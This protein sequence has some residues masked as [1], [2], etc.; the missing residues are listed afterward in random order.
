VQAVTQDKQVALVVQT[1]FA[2]VLQLLTVLV[3]M[4]STITTMVDQTQQQIAEVAHL[5]QQH[6]AVVQMVL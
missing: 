4:E 5:E 2:L 3:V 6:Q 1:L